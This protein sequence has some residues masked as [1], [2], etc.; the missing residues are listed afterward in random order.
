M[1]R[2]R[3]AAPD[4]VKEYPRFTKQMRAT[5]K[6][7][8]PQMA[9][10]H[11]TMIVDV[12]RQKGY[13]VEI[14][15]NDGPNVVHEGLQYV[16][17]DACYP[18]LLVIGQFIDALK[19][20]RYDPDR[21]V[22]VISQTGGGCRASNYIHLLRKALLRAGFAQVPVVSLN[23]SNLER[24]SGLCLTPD[25]LIKAAAACFFGDALMCL[26][27]QVRPYE[28][29]AGDDFNVGLV[30]IGLDVSTRDPAGSDDSDSHFSCG[31]DAFVVSDFLE[32]VET[33]F[34][35]CH[36]C[37]RTFLTLSGLNV[38]AIWAGISGDDGKNS[39]TFPTPVSI[40]TYRS[41]KINN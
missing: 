2:R 14:L 12:L 38:S 33:G 34:C 30:E 11:F 9:P 19:S 37:Y 24:S 35:S 20:G 22:L 10:I 1:S 41:R 36:F 40:L 4:G 26:Y 32:G 21:V 3:A 16:H 5:H 8:V 23:T 17:N 7:L 39:V 15:E 13:D 27:N 31:I 29:C 18:A 25:I 6:L 28:V